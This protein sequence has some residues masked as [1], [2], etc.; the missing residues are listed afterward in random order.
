ML[1]ELRTYTFRPGTVDGWLNGQALAVAG[2]QLDGGEERNLIGSDGAVDL[3]GHAAA[4]GSAGTPV[5]QSR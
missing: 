1:I 3:E 5:S 4:W 2:E